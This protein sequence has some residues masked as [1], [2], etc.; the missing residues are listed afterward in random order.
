MRHFNTWGTEVEIVAFA[1]LTGFDVYV[2]TEQ[3]EW[4][5]YSHSTMSECDVSD[6]AFYTSNDSGCHFDLVTRN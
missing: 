5:H 6:N 3:K 1:Q 2:Y 4:T